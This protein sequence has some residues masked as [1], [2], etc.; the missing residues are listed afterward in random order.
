MNVN[1][2]HYFLVNDT[3]EYKAET[4]HSYDDSDKAWRNLQTLYEMCIPALNLILQ[5]TFVMLLR[6]TVHFN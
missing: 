5:F 2:I 1:N 4:E 6:Y 3:V